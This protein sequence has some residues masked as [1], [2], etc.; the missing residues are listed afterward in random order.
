VPRPVP[1]Q[2]SARGHAVRATA[3]PHTGARPALARKIDVAL[4]RSRRGTRMRDAP[5]NEDARMTITV[6]LPT[7]VALP[8]ATPDGSRYV[9]YDPYTPCARGAPRRGG[10]RSLG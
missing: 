9:P 10:S 5:T 3:R 7:T 1:T 8:D 4:M 6:L 2:P